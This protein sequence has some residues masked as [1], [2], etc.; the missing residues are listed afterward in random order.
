MCSSVSYLKWFPLHYSFHI[1]T[2]S[3]QNHFLNKTSLSLLN[4]LL[5]CFILGIR[6]IN[7]KLWNSEI[8]LINN[9]ILKYTQNY[10]CS[11]RDGKLGYFVGKYRRM[12]ICFLIP[13]SFYCFCG[14]L[15]FIVYDG[16]LSYYLTSDTN[17]SILKQ[18]VYDKTEL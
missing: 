8:I 10:F 18:S 7:L 4:T 15:S 17:V 5:S 16:S 12:F 13:F 6:S 9:R 11:L 3:N 2:E 1:D 14:I